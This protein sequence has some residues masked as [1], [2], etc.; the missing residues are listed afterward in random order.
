MKDKYKEG[1]SNKFWGDN[2]TLPALA[3]TLMGSVIMILSP[4]EFDILKWVGGVLTF[5]CMYSVLKCYASRGF[6]LDAT[7]EY[8][9]SMEKLLAHKDKLIES[10]QKEIQLTREYAVLMEKK[11]EVIN[12]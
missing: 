1:V 2:L 5:L 3:S 6:V 10:Y 9:D 12:G 8:A 4:A 11:S 7:N